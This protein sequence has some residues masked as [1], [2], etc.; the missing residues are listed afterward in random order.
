[1]GKRANKSKNS[2]PRPIN[3]IVLCMAAIKPMTKNWNFGCETTCGYNIELELSFKQ[4][5]LAR[6][7]NDRICCIQHKSS[8]NHAKIIKMFHFILNAF[9]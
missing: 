5:S 9:N 6:C 2:I 3:F 8:D 1:M 7:E 4:I